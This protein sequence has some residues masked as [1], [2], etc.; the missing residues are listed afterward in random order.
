MDQYERSMDNLGIS[1]HYPR[2]ILGDLGRS[3][4]IHGNLFGY[5]TPRWLDSETG[6]PRKVAGFFRK[7]PIFSQIVKSAESAN[8]GQIQFRCRRPRD[9]VRS[10]A[11]TGVTD[12]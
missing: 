1:F 4:D 2:N 8:F 7:T 10:C 11:V 5:P 6:F 12:G 9:T 3:L